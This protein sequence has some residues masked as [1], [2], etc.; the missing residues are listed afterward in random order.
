MISLRLVGISV[1]VVVGI[2]FS[3]PGE[4]FGAE[5]YPTREIQLIIPFQPGDTDNVLRPFVEKMPEYLGQPVTFV[6]KPGAAG[7]VGAGYVASSKPDGYRL[8]GTS[9][10]SIV[11]KPLT[12]KD[13]PYNW[14]SFAP[15]SA[16]TEACLLLVVKSD[17]PWKNLKEL[18]EYAKKNPGKINY[19]SSGTLGGH[20]IAVTAFSNEAGIEMTHIPSQGSGPAVTALLGGHVDMACTAI[21]PAFPHLRAGTLRP[22]AVFNKKRYR[23]LP[24]VPNFIELGYNITLPGRYGMLAPK[25]TPNEIIQT[26]H[27]TLKKIVDKNEKYLDERLRNLGSQ[28][29]FLG[30]E[31]Y[32]EF[33][34]DAH[35]YMSKVVKS[36]MSVK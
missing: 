36:M 29:G 17:G 12:E 21:T 32:R 30:P 9:E 24:D 14:Q 2:M 34:Q 13:L 33:L 15:I 22:L 28:L 25:G 31:E 5:K 6:H 1:L 35:D 19:T 26:L 3:V 7:A 20:H 4:G 23:A 8:L 18:V 27:I 11:I 16:L 10:S